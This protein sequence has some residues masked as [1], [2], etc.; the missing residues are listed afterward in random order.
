MAEK[1]YIE[2]SVLNGESVT[3]VVIQNFVIK[4]WSSPGF[5]II[6]STFNKQP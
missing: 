3:L 6:D 5:A 4:S 2:T 1:V